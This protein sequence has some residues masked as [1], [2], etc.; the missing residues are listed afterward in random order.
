LLLGS[1]VDYCKKKASA[2]FY[3]VL[4]KLGEIKKLEKIQRN[5]TKLVMKLKSLTYKDLVLHLEL[6][7]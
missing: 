4:F 1:H 3:T 7:I 5:A 6:P 2:T